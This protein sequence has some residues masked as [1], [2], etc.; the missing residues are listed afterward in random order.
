MSFPGVD[1]NLN[2]PARCLRPAG[3][4]CAAWWDLPAHLCVIW[5][6]RHNGH[7][8]VARVFD[9]ERGGGWRR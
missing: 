1:A 3:H 7:R 2:G 4:R 5:E 6:V 9:E 8:L